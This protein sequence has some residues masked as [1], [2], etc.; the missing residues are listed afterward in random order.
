MAITHKQLTDMFG[1]SSVKDSA[2]GIKVYKAFK[3][4]VEIFGKK[5]EL[6]VIIPGGTNEIHT[7]ENLNLDELKTLLPRWVESAKK[8]KPAQVNAQDIFEVKV[9]R[10]HALGKEEVIRGDDFPARMLKHSYGR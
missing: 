4:G 9:F 2:Y 7:L 6:E 8:K 1:F 3:S 5:N 10:E